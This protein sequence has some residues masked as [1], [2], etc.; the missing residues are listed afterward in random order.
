MEILF[1]FVKSA[2]FLWLFRLFASPPSM[3]QAVPV[4]GS[5]RTSFFALRELLEIRLC[6]QRVRCSVLTPLERAAVGGAQ[7][8]L[9]KRLG[10]TMGDGK[11]RCE[12]VRM[13]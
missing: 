1:S 5:A 11:I 7:G 12:S 13:L 2:F 9:R 3:F 6:F 8:Q 10:K 4:A